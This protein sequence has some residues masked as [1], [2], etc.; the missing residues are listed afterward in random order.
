[1][2][3]IKMEHILAA[4]G[5]VSFVLFV[6]AGGVEGWQADAQL[7]SGRWT[8]PMWTLLS[9]SVLLFIGAF[10]AHRRRRN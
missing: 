5:S 10:I 2:K 6:I 7:Q 3:N 1:M 8:A 4:L 9:T